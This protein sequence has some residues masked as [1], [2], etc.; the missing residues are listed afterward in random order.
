MPSHEED[1][2][3]TVIV[4]ESLAKDFNRDLAPLTRTTTL[5]PKLGVNDTH[6]VTTLSRGLAMLKN[7]FTI[8]K[9]SIQSTHI[10]KTLIT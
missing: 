8:M 5:G 6:N 3:L 1:L 7:N 9:S 2:P 4:E 10:N